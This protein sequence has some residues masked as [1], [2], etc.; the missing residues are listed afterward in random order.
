MK[1]LQFTIPVAH[2]LTIIVQE[3]NMSHFYPYLHRHKEAQLIWIKEGEGTLV[4]D[5]NMHAFRKNDIYLLGANQPHLFK[6]N[7]EYFEEGSD[8]KIQ[9]LMIFF[10]PNGRLAPILALPEMQL[11]QSFLQQKQSG[12]KVPTTQTDA[13]IQRMLS[14]Q[15]AK[16]HEVVVKF[17]DLLQA[18]YQDGNKGETLSSAKMASFS[19]T[20]G[21]RIGN[22]FN[23]LMQHYE[24]QIS[25]DEVASEAHMTPQAFCRYFK[26]HT[27]QTFVSFLN[28]LRIN[29]ACKKLTSGKFENIATVVYTCG[30]NSVTNFNRVFKSVK[31][32]APKTYL[33]HYFKNFK[34]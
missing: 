16:N 17:L 27:R 15:Y 4:V 25:L 31:G 13:I 20:E 8:L 11:L 18:L 28:E 7:P 1:V 26:K 14:V 3:D 33:A 21:I 10:D 29:E 24:R 6:S 5:N 22:I 9:A 32:E 12:Y 19:E 23:Y 2:D 30:F 34:T